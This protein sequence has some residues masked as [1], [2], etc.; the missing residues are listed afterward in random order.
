MMNDDRQEALELDVVKE[1]IVRHCAFSL[2]KQKIR[3]TY[4]NYDK[5]WV[6]RELKRSKE[7]FDLV[8][9]YG[10]M[11]FGGIRD[12][13]LS[14][15]DALKG[16]TIRAQELRQIAESIRGSEAMRKYMKS[17]E[18][19]TPLIQELVDS[20]SDHVKCAVKIESCINVN[21][22]LLDNASSELKRIRKAVHACEQEIA[23]E[24]QRFISRHSSQ[25]M[26]TI[27]TMR[28]DRTC[29]LV[30]ISEKNSVDGML[31]G[32]SASGQTAY[33]EPRSLVNLNNKLQSLKSK[34]KDEI[35]RILSMLSK[36]VAAIGYELLAN[37][38][39]YALLDSIFAKGC[40]AKEVDGCIAE[41]NET[42]E[43]LYFKRAAHPL[44]EKDHVV[45]NTYEI[46]PPFHS[47]LIT[48]SNTGGKTVT[49]KT[50][51]LFAAMT[52]CGFPI[53]AEEGCIPLFD[54][55]YVDIGD[56]QSIQESLSTFSSHISKM[57]YITQHAGPCSLV[58]LD[59]LGSG[60]DPKEGEPLAVAILDDL[61]KKHAMVIATTH[62]SALKSY[63]ADHEDVLLSSVEFDMEQMRPTYHYIEGIS[64]QSNAFE[65]ARRY[66]LSETILSKAQ[67][68]KEVA[69]TKSEEAME[70]LEASLME[71]HDLKKQLEEKLED[72]RKL[73]EQL[74]DEKEALAKQKDRILAELKEKTEKS[75]EE[76]LQ[77]AE[78]IIDL[79]K[80]LKS[81]AKPHEITELKSALHALH[82]EEEEAAEKKDE[83]FEIGD[84]VK[85]DKL[86]YYGDIISVNKD[87]VCVLANGM[88]MNTTTKEISHAKKQVEKKK[89]TKGYAKSGVKSFS[90]EVNVIGMRVAEAIP[91]VD[92]YLDNALLAKVYRV[93]VIHGMGTGALRK[94]VHDYLKHN[95]RVESFVMGGQ[96]EGGLGATVVTLKQ[97]K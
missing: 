32:E 23:S 89:K 3:S 33:I 5:L 69:K 39:T 2:G 61:R 22:E 36:E 9:R 80:E 92:K 27:T 4:P 83:V 60:T 65:I 43:R 1:Q 48:G 84:Y 54:G 95:P 6:E 78:E 35:E 71:H 53:A 79:L 14:V 7:A 66:G 45:V 97:K 76:K 81:E 42:E 13:A 58:L 19:Q 21:Y 57:A 16:I 30:K 29:V 62:Y 68:R 77:E 40:W 94:G 20:L 41:V 85:L 96:G 74:Q 8:V 46:K 64:G 49:L 75:M 50:I 63:G 47:L 82:E 10:V 70:K 56:D 91:I 86:N 11:P 52:M 93:R 31:H 44:I 24:V 51:G 12:I 34:E 15:E 25:L 59:E 73:Q 90:M 67:E 55:I 18:I 28:N 87:K 72:V 88:K 37:L 38:D 17:S 26:D